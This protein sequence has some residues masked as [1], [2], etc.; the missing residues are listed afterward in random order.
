M[1]VVDAETQEAVPSP[2][3]YLE[4]QRDGATQDKG[5]LKMQFAA[6]E[7]GSLALPPLAPGPLVVAASAEGYLRSPP[8]AFDVIQL[9]KQHEIRI[10]LEKGVDPKILGFLRPDGEP[11]A[12]LEIRAQGGLDDSLPSFEGFTNA[13]GEIEIPA[14]I[15]GLYL[16]WRDPSGRLA[17]GYQSY[18][19]ENAGDNEKIVLSFRAPLVLRVTDRS[20]LPA[21]NVALLVW[22]PTG[23]LLEGE[24]LQFLYE[25][26]T[27]DAHGFFRVRGA[28]AQT[29]TVL[30]YD[31]ASK[32]S[33]FDPLASQITWPWPAIVPLEKVD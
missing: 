3:I 8:M 14:Q 18:L 12:G 6:G 26:K 23:E 19:A 25:A 21:A 15:D 10:L 32:H 27:T 24:T 7:D 16:L 22:G 31:R 9:G 33:S 1:V 29:F 4:L 11:A 20:G 13:S 2:R 17:S 5:P 28:T 30:A